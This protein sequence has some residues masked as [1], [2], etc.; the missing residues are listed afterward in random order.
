M[1]SSYLIIPSWEISVFAFMLKHPA[2]KLERYTLMLFLLGGV[3]WPWFKRG[4]C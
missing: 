2:V 4:L 1:E 3:E